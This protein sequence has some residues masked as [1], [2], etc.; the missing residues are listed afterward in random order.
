[1]GEFARETER[2]KGCY[3]PSAHGGQIA[4]SASQ[5]TV[6]NGFGRVPVKAKVTACYGEVGSNRHLFAWAKA[7]EGAIVPD[8]QAQRGGSEI[9]RPTPKSFQQ[10]QFSRSA[11]F[12]RRGLPSAHLIEHTFCR[13]WHRE[14]EPTAMRI[15]QAE[16]R[17]FQR[18]FV[19]LTGLGC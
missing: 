2:E 18:D 9:R 13:S 16:W 11:G 6:A 17:I 12:D 10:S 1:M 15:I 8:S 14:I 7:D 4:E 5:G 19:D 3:R